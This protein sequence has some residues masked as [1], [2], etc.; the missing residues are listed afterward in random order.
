MTPC[1]PCAQMGLGC[2]VWGPGASSWGWHESGRRMRGPSGG[3]SCPLSTV[4]SS[5]RRS[6][7]AVHPQEACAGLAGRL[8]RRTTTTPSVWGG[9]SC[10]REIGRKTQVD[11]RPHLRR[12]DGAENSPLPRTAAFVIRPRALCSLD[13]GEMSQQQQQHSA[14][15]ESTFETMCLGPISTSREEREKTKHQTNKRESTGRRWGGSRIGVSRA[16]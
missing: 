15:I 16:S 8:L 7:G 10:C 11:G 14:N 1:I 13:P 5:G 3:E 2:R 6:S 12:T 9:G 4:P